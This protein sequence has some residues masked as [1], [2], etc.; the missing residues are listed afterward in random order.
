MSN[1]NAPAFPLSNADFAHAMGMAASVRIG[2]SA[3]RERTYI[4]ARAQAVK[5]LTKRE[6]FAAM[7]LSGLCANPGH[8]DR[9][10][11]Y[12]ASDAVDYADALLAQLAKP[13]EPPL[14]ARGN[15]VNM[16]AD[17]IVALERIKTG[18]ERALTGLPGTDMPRE[19]A[20]A[21]LEIAA[22]ALVKVK[23]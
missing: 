18:A 11:D 2:D 12:Q 7:A 6:H 19:M 4:E 13:Q 21:I 10:A 1:A 14:D 5:G 20:Q 16:P 3:E 15:A 17:L 8:Q 23:L 22:E 9:R